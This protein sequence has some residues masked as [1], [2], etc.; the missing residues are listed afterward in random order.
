MANALLRPYLHSA[1]QIRWS[2][3]I[4]TPTAITHAKWGITGGFTFRTTEI[5]I[6]YLEISLPGLL[7]KE[8][9]FLLLHQLHHVFGLWDHVFYQLPVLNVSSKPEFN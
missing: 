8:I 1:T 5:L 7:L 3:S 9:L 4:Y 6:N 2:V